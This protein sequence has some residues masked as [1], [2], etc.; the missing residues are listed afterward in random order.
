MKS[1]NVFLTFLKQMLKA[2]SNM[3]ESSSSQFL[4][5]ASQLSSGPG[6]LE[7]WRT[8][9]VYLT[10]LRITEKSF[11]FRLMLEEKISYRA[12]RVMKV[13]VLYSERPLNGG[14]TFVETSFTMTIL[15]KVLKMKRSTSYKFIV[16]ST[17]TQSITWTKNIHNSTKSITEA[18]LWLQ[19]Q[20]QI[21]DGRKSMVIDGEEKKS[22]TEWTKAKQEHK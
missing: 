5:T 15:R 8:V 22:G 2:S 21:L 11:S 1:V 3:Y 16:K 19:K 17:E 20:H 6:A 18:C 12:P 4:R 7:K 10:V 13:K 9:T 14:I